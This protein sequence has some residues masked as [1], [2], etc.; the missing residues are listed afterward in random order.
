MFGRGEY[1]NCCRFLDLGC[2]DD[3]GNHE[4]FP[5]PELYLLVNITDH[6]VTLVRHR[7]ARIDVELQSLL[8]VFHYKDSGHIDLL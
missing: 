8:S 2:C 6:S 5:P 4:P 7:L 3:C 1:H